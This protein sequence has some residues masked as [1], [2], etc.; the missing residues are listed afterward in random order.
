MEQ[1]V[2][3]RVVEEVVDEVESKIHL[4]DVFH[5]C[6]VLSQV[7]EEVGRRN[8]ALV[9]QHQLS[10]LGDALLFCLTELPSDGFGTPGYLHQREQRIITEGSNSKMS[11]CFKKWTKKGNFPLCIFASSLYFCFLFVFL[12]SG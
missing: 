9:G 4:G 1:T 6:H 10:N 3:V 7:A 2:V 12:Q 8:V 5:G 11:E